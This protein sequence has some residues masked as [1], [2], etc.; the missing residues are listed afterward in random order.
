MKV[1]VKGPDGPNAFITFT[2]SGAVEPASEPP[3]EVDARTLRE[4]LAEYGREFNAS[5][6]LYDGSWPSVPFAS[7]DGAKYFIYGSS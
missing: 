1:R 2:P 3:F 7:P 4:A 5:I 6:E